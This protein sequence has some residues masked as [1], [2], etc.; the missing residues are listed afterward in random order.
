ML[1]IKSDGWEQIHFSDTLNSLRRKLGEVHSW[2]AWHVSV[3][4]NTTTISKP[5]VWRFKYSTYPCPTR[6]RLLKRRR[7]GVSLVF[8]SC[9]KVPQCLSGERHV[10]FLSQ[11]HKE[12][13]PCSLDRF[14]SPSVSLYPCCTPEAHAREPCTQAPVLLFVCPPPC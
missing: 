6:V 1:I 9:S 14:L 2:K 12:S 4:F 10:L 7:G 11:P 5:P 8:V 13:A 3:R